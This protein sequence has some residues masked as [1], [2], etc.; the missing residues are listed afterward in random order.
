MITRKEILEDIKEIDKEAY[1]ELKEM[2]NEEMTDEELSEIFDGILDNLRMEEYLG[3]ND[4]F[5]FL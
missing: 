5:N 2:S 1:L 4:E 3:R